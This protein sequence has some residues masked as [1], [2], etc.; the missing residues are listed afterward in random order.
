MSDPVTPPPNTTPAAAKEAPETPAPAKTAQ[1]LVRERA[2]AEAAPLALKP[3]DAPAAAPKETP[4]A[5]PAKETRRAILAGDE[6]DLPDADVLEMPKKAL[7]SRL[8]RASKQ[9]LAKLFEAV[10]VKDRAEFDAK[11]S[12]VKEAEA[13][14]EAARVAQLSKEQALEEE[15]ARLKASEQAWKA[16]HA[17]AVNAQQFRET[18][19]ATVRLA[20]KYIDPEF[21]ELVLPKLGAYLVGKYKDDELKDLPDS[22]V[23]GFFKEYAEKHPK[24]ALAPPAAPPAPP[25][26]VKLTNGAPKEAEAPAPPKGPPAAVSYKPKPGETPEERRAAQAEIR[27]NTGI[28]F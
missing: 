19:Q 12:K 5:P 3:A 13:A 10:G 28:S 25:K 24:V 20:E 22:V 21:T 17:E 8:K 23:E 2:Q 1:D 6:D 15:N 7:E 16:R 14:A 18:Q 27:K 11:W 26:V 4:A 9:E